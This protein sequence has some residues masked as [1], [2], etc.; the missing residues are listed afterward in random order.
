ME[1]CSIPAQSWAFLGTCWSPT[2]Q[3][4]RGSEAV[5]AENALMYNCCFTLLRRSPNTY[6][7]LPFSMLTDTSKFLELLVLSRKSALFTPLVPLVGTRQGTHPS[8][9]M[10][11]KD[12][13]GTSKLASKLLLLLRTENRPWTNAATESTQSMN[14][15]PT[16]QNITYLT[17]DTML[18]FAYIKPCVESCRVCCPRRVYVHC[19][20]KI[21]HRSTNTRDAQTN[22][23][24][25]MI[26]FVTTKNNNYQHM[27][28]K[29]STI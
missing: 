11:R 27:L 4:Q 1:H 10:L 24:W 2:W 20:K 9:L 23:K 21:F 3:K 16:M 5:M 22:W 8:S 18:Y 6:S 28:N 14:W 19:I 13:I 15:Q 26:D 17:T 25:E 12:C 29:Q 7:L